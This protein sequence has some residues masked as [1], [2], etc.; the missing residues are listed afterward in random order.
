MTINKTIKN[1][2]EKIAEKI[3]NAKSIAIFANTS[4]DPDGLGSM[5]GLAH[6]L[7]KQGKNVDKFV[8]SKICPT[9][10][11]FFDI[12]QLCDEIT[13]DYD[14]MIMVDTANVERLGKY[15]SAFAKHNNTIRLDHHVGYHTCAKIEVVLPLSSCCE[16]ILA[17]IESLGKKPD[18]ITATYLFGGLL[19]DTDCFSTDT[20]TAVSFQ[21][22]CKLI[23]CGADNVKATSMLV[24]SQSQAQYNLSKIVADKCEIHGD[25]YISSLTLKDYKKAG[26]QLNE[27]GNISNKLIY[28][29]G[30]N[31]SCLI[32]Q[33][34]INV[35]SCS[36]RGR[37]GT[38]VSVI[39]NKLG[40][41]GH[42]LAAGAVIKGS[43]KSVKALILKTIRENRK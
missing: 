22:A 28:L 33:R 7:E 37:V 32:K 18:K 39:A 23:E 8:D 16:V 41:G 20:I 9:D 12:S 2:F 17:Y 40:G 35:F 36:F 19:T 15:A 26:A 43:E 3:K 38:D 29:E 21:N 11:K 5:Y 10:A 1:K 30:I 14:L 42:K 13:R 31:I 4:Y 25:V 34:Q 24:K 6:F 27:D